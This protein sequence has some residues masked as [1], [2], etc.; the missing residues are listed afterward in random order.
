LPA[1][2]ADHFINLA[3]QNNFFVTEKIIVKQTSTHQP[4]RNFLLFSTAHSEPSVK[5]WCIKDKNEKYTEVFSALLKDY[6]L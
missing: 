2:R 6:Y 3:E 1:S 4:F 5:E